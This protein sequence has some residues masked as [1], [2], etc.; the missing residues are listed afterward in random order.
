MQENSIGDKRIDSFIKSVSSQLKRKII[1]QSVLDKVYEFDD[2]K[3]H[4]TAS[5]S[6][7]INNEGSTNIT[8]D[9][10]WNSPH[11]KPISLAIGES[12]INSR[13]VLNFKDAYLLGS[14]PS[15][16]TNYKL[17]SPDNILSDTRKYDDSIKSIISS[18]F[19]ATV[20]SRHIRHA[21]LVSRHSDSFGHWATEVLP[22]LKI[23]EKYNKSIDYEL[24][25]IIGNE[26][27]SWQKESLRLMGYDVD[28]IFKHKMGKS[29]IHDLHVP[30]HSHLAGYQL[31]RYPSPEDLR[32]V[33]RCILN[34][35]PET[36]NS[37][38]DRIY[39][40]RADVD[41]R[42]VINKDEVMDVLHKFGFKTY[43]PGEMTFT[44]QAE[45]FAGANIIIGPHGAGLLNTIFAN[46]ATLIEF[47]IPEKTNIHF[48]VLANLMRLDYEY[49]CSE[50][51]SEDD[52]YFG[53]SDMNVN[54][55]DLDNVLKKLLG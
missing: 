47:V 36:E 8:Y 17:I 45:L 54:T 35:L 14:T 12:K 5:G 41:R 39:I 25:L 50:A 20:P 51:K 55:E 21:F 44:D 4:S 26:L 18:Y 42:Q 32:W 10:I 34:N 48:F 2:H 6:V 33:Q 13:E 31:G 46:D 24:N 38:G 43:V 23:F 1:A 9:G 37:F 19:G 27:N 53:H 15:I 3:I 28:S 7:N 40:S 16:L 30:S 11:P 49:V 22:K 52:V 29:F